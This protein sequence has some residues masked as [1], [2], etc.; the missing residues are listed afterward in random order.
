MLKYEGTYFRAML[1]NETWL[2]GDGGMNLRDFSSY[3]QFCILYEREISSALYLDLSSCIGAYFIDSDPK[4]FN[5]VLEYLRSGRL[6][7]IEDFSRT[8]NNKIREHFE[9]FQLPIP[10][11]LARHQQ[12][13][14]P[15]R[16]RK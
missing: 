8:K 11:Q 2:P 10:E 9:Y 15:T 3:V 12:I 13:V 5:Y 14:I 16:W 6:D 1:L 7:G 4:Y